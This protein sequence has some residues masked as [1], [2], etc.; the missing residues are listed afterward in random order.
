MNFK[1][2]SINEI[3]NKFKLNKY[4]LNIDL[5]SIDRFWISSKIITIDLL[6]SVHDNIDWS[7]S[8]TEMNIVDI[9]L[10]I[11][12]KINWKTLFLN[13]NA[14]ELLVEVQDKI[15]KQFIFVDPKFIQDLLE[16]KHDKFD[17]MIDQEI[18]EDNSLN[19]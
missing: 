18:D 3:Y 19:Y 17:Q 2:L 10:N 14:L 4:Y 12:H 11:Q 8:P 6:E 9:I 5:V 7:Q 15:D 1:L 13:P 16:K